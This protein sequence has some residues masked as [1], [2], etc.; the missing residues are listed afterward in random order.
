[1]KR[2]TKLKLMA[3]VV[4]LGL[5]TGYVAS[6]P[7][8]VRLGNELP[9]YKPVRDAVAKVATYAYGDQV[10]VDDKFVNAYIATLKKGYEEAGNHM[11]SDYDADSIIYYQNELWEF[12][13]W[14]P[15]LDEVKAN[16]V[17]EKTLDLTINQ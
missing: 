2:E 8:N 12:Y 1:M 15:E 7:Y 6:S 11:I 4:V 14:I 16:L 17:D 13:D 9:E 10:E 5:A 3:G